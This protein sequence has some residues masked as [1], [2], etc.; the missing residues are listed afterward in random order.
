M[1]QVFNYANTKKPLENSP[2]TSTCASIVQI[3][4][5]RSSRIQQSEYLY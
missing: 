2:D 5:S 3:I 1:Q 4:Q